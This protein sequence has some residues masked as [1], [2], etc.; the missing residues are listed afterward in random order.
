MEIYNFLQKVSVDYALFAQHHD[1][2]VKLAS[3]FFSVK[4]NYFELE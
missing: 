2:K 3:N 4:P 1:Y